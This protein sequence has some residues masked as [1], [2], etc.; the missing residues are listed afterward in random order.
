MLLFRGLDLMIL[1]AQSIPVPEDFQTIA[2]GFLPEI[3]PDTGYHNP[4]L[5]LSLLA[6]RAARGARAPQARRA[7]QVRHDAS[8][9]S[10]WSS[11]SWSSPAAVLM[12]VGVLLASYKGMPVVGLILVAL[13]IIYTFITQR[14][15]IGRH[16]YSV[17][18]NRNAA[19]CPV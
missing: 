16:I 19:R 18:G 7:A 8:R 14:T 5:V 10:R 6:H 15:V 4:T 13:V 11:S 2:N 3:G 9:R 12:A 17:G 1:D